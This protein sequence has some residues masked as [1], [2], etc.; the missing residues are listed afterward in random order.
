MK[1]SCHTTR[2][3]N[4]RIRTGDDIPQVESL[5]TLDALV[6]DLA[7]IVN[8]EGQ[9][10]QC[11]EYGRQQEEDHHHVKSAVQCAHQLWEDYST[12]TLGYTFI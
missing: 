1:N 6:G 3:N 11:K 8:A 4:V 7:C 9:T 12:H 2:E 10:D 5:V